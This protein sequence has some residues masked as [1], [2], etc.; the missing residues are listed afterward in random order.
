MEI[1]SSM[2]AAVGSFDPRSLD[3]TRLAAKSGDAGANKK[4]AQQFESMFL[5]MMLKNMRA[6]LPGSDPLANEASKMATDLYDQQ[7][8]QNLSK[9]RG[10]GLADAIVAQ[11]ERSQ[12]KA[13]A[14]QGGASRAAVPPVGGSLP[15]PGTLGPLGDAAERFAPST[16][17]IGT[18]P[19]SMPAMPQARTIVDQAATRN[20]DATA[21]ATAAPSTVR[22]VHRDFVERFKDAADAASRVSGMP[23]KV[24]LGQ[25]ALESGW[26]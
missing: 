6:T 2:N 17:L 1:P 10:M 4:V 12:G 26:G 25:A 24:I 3:A 15:A 8:A 16:H 14:A 21:T 22:L 20:S 11:I 23:S 7:L 5:A 18:T 13:V 19:G 9:G